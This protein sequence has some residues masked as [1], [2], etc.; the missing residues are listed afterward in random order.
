LKRGDNYRFRPFDTASSLLVFTQKVFKAC[1][2]FFRVTFFTDSYRDSIQFTIRELSQ[3]LTIISLKHTPN[4]I[5][6]YK[7]E[8]EGSR[9]SEID[10]EIEPNL[11]DLAEFLKHLL[12]EQVPSIIL[13]E[14]TETLHD[15]WAQRLADFIDNEF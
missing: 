3:K 6:V 9:Q 14:E 7:Q 10:E 1:G 5:E 2:L 12:I 15:D 11:E 4:L 13:D 8:N